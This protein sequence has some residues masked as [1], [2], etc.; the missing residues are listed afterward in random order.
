[1]LTNRYISFCKHIVNEFVDKYKNPDYNEYKQNK[2][3]QRNESVK[4]RNLPCQIIILIK[5]INKM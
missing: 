5:K 4:K 2:N 3:S 1:M